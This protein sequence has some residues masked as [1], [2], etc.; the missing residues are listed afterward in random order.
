[1]DLEAIFGVIKE[2]DYWNKSKVPFKTLSEKHSYLTVARKET[3]Q[4]EHI[5]MK[6]L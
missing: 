2:K 6:R 3:L 4:T 5:L 1:M